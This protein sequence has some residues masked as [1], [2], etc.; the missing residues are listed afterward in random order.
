[1]YKGINN[2]IRSVF[3]VIAVMAACIGLAACSGGSTLGI[4]KPTIDLN[5]EQSSL[6]LEPLM[7]G[8]ELADVPESASTEEEDNA[9]KDYFRCI[10]DKIDGIKL[11]MD[12][13]ALDI[14]D[15]VPIIDKQIPAFVMLSVGNNNPQLMT[16][17]AL[18]GA[19][20]PLAPYHFVFACPRSVSGCEDVGKGDKIN[21]VAEFDTESTIVPTE[22]MP[23]A[24]VTSIAIS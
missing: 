13:I 15:E 24:I 12:G 5:S 19:E 20:K 23:T 4:T 1:M 10:G 2:M 3:S 22:G 14:I 9:L 8:C 11:T 17:I 7:E 6:Q 16:T 18:P 21:V